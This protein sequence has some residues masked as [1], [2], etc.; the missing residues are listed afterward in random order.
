MN[1]LKWQDPCLG[2]VSQVVYSII[3]EGDFGKEVIRESGRGIIPSLEGGNTWR[4]LR[5][6]ISAIHYESVVNGA[7]ELCKLFA[8][9]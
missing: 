5:D 1:Q 6:I 9:V 4:G 8:S 3:I 7:S 2:P